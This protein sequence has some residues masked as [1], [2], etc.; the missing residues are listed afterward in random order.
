MRE[1]DQW[2]SIPGIL[3]YFHK[4][5]LVTRFIDLSVSPLYYYMMTE[6]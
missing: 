6:P 4:A 1:K 5:N 2:W 3:T